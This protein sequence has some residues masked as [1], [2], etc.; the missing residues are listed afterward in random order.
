MSSK[1]ATS[2]PA[3]T[4]PR[5]HAAN[6]PHFPGGK[7]QYSTRLMTPCPAGILWPTMTPEVPVVESDPGSNTLPRSTLDA[8]TLHTPGCRHQAP[9]SRCASLLK[10]VCQSL[11]ALGLG[12]AS[13]YLISNYFVQSV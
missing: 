9:S 4:L 6:R 7:H 1:Y 5:S 12:L 2:S 10:Q 11:I 13:Y 3:P 8:P